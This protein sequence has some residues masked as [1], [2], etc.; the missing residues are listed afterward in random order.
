MIE[1]KYEK[2]PF[3]KVCLGGTF[4][5]LHEGH[6]NL[7]KTAFQLGC[8]VAIGITTETLLRHKKHHSMIQSYE[9]RKKN[10][11]DLLIQEFNFAPHTFTI[12]P[13][14][15]PF[16]P[17]IEEPDLEA[18]ICSQETYRGCMKINEIRMRKGLTPTKIIIIPLTLNS[19]GTKLSSTDIRTEIL[20]MEGEC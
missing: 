7:L 19:S 9:N 12:L 14:K 15:D 2:K 11:R 13:L 20:H 18:Q 8:H 5:H 17:A 3:Q 6:R 4:D 10:L 1:D 16:G